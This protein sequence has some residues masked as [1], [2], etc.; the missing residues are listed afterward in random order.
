MTIT[1]IGYK[2]NMKRH[3][4]IMQDNIQ[5]NQKL[6]IKTSTTR[7][8]KKKIILCLKKRMSHTSQ[9]SPRTI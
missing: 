5:N 7:E 3:T 6:A 1:Q 2:A 8:L 4:E 9:D